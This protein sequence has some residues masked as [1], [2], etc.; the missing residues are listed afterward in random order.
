MILKQCSTCSVSVCAVLSTLWLWPAHLFSTIIETRERTVTYRAWLLDLIASH[1]S[2]NSALNFLHLQWNI[3][4]FG[5]INNNPTHRL[6]H[7]KLSR[8]LVPVMNPYAKD[9]IRLS[10]N[11][12]GRH[13]SKLNRGN[14]THG[15]ME[16]I[17]QIHWTGK[18]RA[19]RKLEN[20]S[21]SSR[22]GK[23]FNRSKKMIFTS[24]PASFWT[25]LLRWTLK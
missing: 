18:Y 9:N 8:S 1:I 14:S 16:V 15:I 3:T 10:N 12:K 24:D 19:G 20:T 2:A 6:S 5:N 7:K 22:V 13:H 25:L 4:G 21:F 17:V 11:I 23:K